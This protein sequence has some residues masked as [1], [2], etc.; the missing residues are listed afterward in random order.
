[1]AQNGCPLESDWLCQAVDARVKGV[2]GVATHHMG[3]PI[4]SDL[5]SW[6]MPGRVD[7]RL[8]KPRVRQRYPSRYVTYETL[9]IPLPPRPH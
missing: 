7:A 1:M 9:S 2:A 5:S 6:R 3:K 8:I 4:S